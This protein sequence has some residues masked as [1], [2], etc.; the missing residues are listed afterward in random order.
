MDKYQALLIVFVA[1][2]LIGLNGTLLWE[3]S[4]RLEY[5]SEIDVC[6]DIFCLRSCVC[7]VAGS[8]VM[9]FEQFWVFYLFCI[10]YI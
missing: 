1:M 7:I 4:M 2:F 5:A 3:L 10:T 9:K 6:F 8:F